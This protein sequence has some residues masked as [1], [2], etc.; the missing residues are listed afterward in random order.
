MY[1][2]FD[3]IKMKTVEMALINK[4]YYKVIFLTKQCML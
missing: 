2:I 1:R 4:D 3:M